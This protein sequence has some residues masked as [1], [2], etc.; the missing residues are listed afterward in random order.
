MIEEKGKQPPRLSVLNIGKRPTFGSD[1]TLTVEVH[2]IDFS[3]DLYR[4]TLEL[5][6]FNFIREEQLFANADVLQVQIEKDIAFTKE[7]FNFIDNT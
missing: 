5:S 2:L 6:N 1:S 7:K 4:R 3:G